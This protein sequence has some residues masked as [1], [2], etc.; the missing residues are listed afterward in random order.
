[1][2]CQGLFWRPRKKIIDDFFQGLEVMPSV[3]VEGPAVATFM[4]S[5][6]GVPKLCHK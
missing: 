3:S 6:L 1:M 4:L 5:Y 2:G